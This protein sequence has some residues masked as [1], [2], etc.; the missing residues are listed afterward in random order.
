LKIE[1]NK[2]TLNEIR[3]LRMLFLQENKFQFVHDK[4]H[5]YGWSDD[6]LFLIDGIK[7]G[8]GC[9]WGGNNR[10]DRDTIFEFYLEPPF[11]SFSNTFFSSLVDVSKASFV[12]CQSNDHFMSAIV[13]EQA[14]N[15]NAEAI[16]FEDNNQTEL[17]FPDIIFKR[18]GKLNSNPND[19]GEYILVKDGEVVAN[20]GF[21]LNY[22]FPYADIYMEV[23]ENFRGR[24]YCGL[25]VQE[26]KKEIYAIGR[27]PAARCNIKNLMSKSC[28]QKAGFKPC[29]FILRAEIT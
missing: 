9:V 18:S 3:E 26:L 6:Y 12:E 7:A 20:G 16:L 19:S 8:Y 11:R 14:K 1:I 24:G 15:I 27:V 13:F 5:Y 21:M 17:F 22:N 25:I 28:L 23:N 29:G 2:T 10:D 4:C